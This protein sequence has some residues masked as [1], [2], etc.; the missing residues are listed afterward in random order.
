MSTCIQ[1]SVTTNFA[2]SF[3]TF[4]PNQ[5]NYL[6]L[7]FLLQHLTTAND[8]AS[9]PVFRPLLL[10]PSLKVSKCSALVLNSGIRVPLCA[11]TRSSIPSEHPQ[12]C[13]HPLQIPFFLGLSINHIGSLFPESIP[14]QRSLFYF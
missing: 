11:P 5:T 8:L 13:N 12:P 4:S 10:G 14:F 3:L 1:Y 7:T 6:I 2:T 9:F